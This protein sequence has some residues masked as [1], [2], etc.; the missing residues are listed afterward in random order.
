MT[1]QQ[2]SPEQMATGEGAGEYSG[3]YKVRGW[4]PI[5]GGLCWVL[6]LTV[7]RSARRRLARAKAP[8]CG[9]AKQAAS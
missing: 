4:Q 1:E 5:A 7:Q 2:S 3:N 6:P 9:L 8:R